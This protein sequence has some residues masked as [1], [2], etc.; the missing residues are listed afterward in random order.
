VWLPARRGAALVVRRATPGGRCALEI[1]RERDG[2]PAGEAVMV[3]HHE[4]LK[5]AGLL[6]AAGRGQAGFDCLWCGWEAR[7]ALRVLWRRGPEA[8]GFCVEALGPRGGCRWRLELLDAKRMPLEL[9]RAIRWLLAPA[10][11]PKSES[12]IAAMI[13]ERVQDRAVGRG[14]S[15]R[16]PGSG[17]ER[18]SSFNPESAFARPISRE[19]AKEFEP[20]LGIAWDHYEHRGS[21]F[22]LL[23]GPP[24]FDLETG[25]LF[26][27]HGVFSESGAWIGADRP[28]PHRRITNGVLEALS[29]AEIESIF[30]RYQNGDYGEGECGFAV[31]ESR[32]GHQLFLIDDATRSL[33]GE[34]PL[35]D[36]D[37]SPGPQ[38]L[39]LSREY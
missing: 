35:R 28:V 2:E 25:R 6:D 24:P 16:R 31:Y 36:P 19:R 15:T 20:G 11:S 3:P 33:E 10:E 34:P 26:E 12:E 4:A 8:P 5:L 21:S 30:E 23:S 22:K 13:R 18:R 14:G 39:M 1:T 27:D 37:T 9:T 38:T 7:P 32:A 17:V 29:G